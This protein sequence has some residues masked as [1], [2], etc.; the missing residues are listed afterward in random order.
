MSTPR[1]LLIGLAATIGGLI[2]ACIALLVATTT[3]SAVGI[4]PTP[5]PTQPKTP[6]S[7]SIPGPTPTPA[8]FIHDPTKSPGSNDRFTLLVSSAGWTNRADLQPPPGQRYLLLL[9]Q[10]SPNPRA[11]KQFQGGT[12]Y[13]SSFRLV[14]NGTQLAPDQAARETIDARGFGDTLGTTIK[15]RQRRTLIFLVPDDAERFELR[16][17]SGSADPITFTLRLPAPGQATPTE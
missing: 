16:L 11:S 12:V 3:L 5:E 1:K 4:L 15:S 7:T 6:R 9:V 13:E 2:V 8:Q 10:V 14:V 17:T